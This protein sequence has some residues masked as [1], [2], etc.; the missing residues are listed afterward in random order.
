M[1]RPAVKRDWIH[2]LLVR[3]WPVGLAGA[4]LL[5]WAL[6]SLLVVKKVVALLFLP[7]GLVWLGL[8]VLAGW[9][10]L[11]RG[12]RG[13]AVAMLAI[14]TMAGNAWFG[15]WLLAT[16]EGPYAH[17]PAEVP[18]ADALC[19]LGGGS[20]AR[21]DGSPQLG[22]AGDRLIEAAR[23][24]LTGRAGHLVA[25]GLSVTDLGGGR[26]LA[27]DTA[28]IWRDLGIPES[29]VTLLHEPRTTKEEVRAYR[30]LMDERGWDRIA[31]CSSAW[32]LRRVERICAAEGVRMTPVAADFLSTPLPWSALYAVPQARGFQNVQK[33]LWEYLGAWAGG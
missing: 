24:H 9:P 16:L 17:R 29:A 23:W 10:G 26:S 27:D 3:L 12:R 4:V 14:Y 28:A 31:V 2:P 5:G 22:P 13:W 25:S 20:S 1:E 21:P 18:A 19:V 33:A 7:T 6:P 8:M 30:K 32:H 11:G 15:G